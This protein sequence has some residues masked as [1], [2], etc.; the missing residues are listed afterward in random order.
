MTCSH[1][2][3]KWELRH[4]EKSL[5][6]RKTRGPSIEGPRAPCCPSTAPPSHST[7]Q[8]P[9]TEQFGCSGDPQKLL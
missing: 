5:V 9:S 8:L 3:R 4:E 7:S 6:V 1:L 2:S